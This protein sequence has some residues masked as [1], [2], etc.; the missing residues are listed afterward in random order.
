MVGNLRKCLE[1]MEIGTP[2]S[3]NAME[4]LRLMKDERSL[5]RSSYVT[6]CG[7]EDLI[8]NTK[9][10]SETSGMKHIKPTSKYNYPRDVYMEVILSLSGDHLIRV[11]IRVQ[12]IYL[13]IAFIRSCPGG[14]KYESV[15]KTRIALREIVDGMLLY[16][17]EQLKL[18]L[19]EI[20]T[21]CLRNAVESAADNVVA[22]R[23]REL[24]MDDFEYLMDEV[25]KARE[26]FNKNVWAYMIYFTD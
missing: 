7:C 22:K 1:Y 14:S 4:Y 23:L 17:R 15:L 16:N 13:L 18:A 24:G 10:D 12:S 20:P 21:N 6:F 8:R 19:N 11:L 5:D 2:Q 25:E 26:K 3:R 9:W